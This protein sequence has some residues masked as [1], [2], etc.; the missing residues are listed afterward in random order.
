MTEDTT[1]HEDWKDHDGR[2]DIADHQEDLE[3]GAERDAAVVAGAEDLVG[4]AEHRLVENER[5]GGWT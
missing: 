2:A 5:G 3:E 4:A 1:P